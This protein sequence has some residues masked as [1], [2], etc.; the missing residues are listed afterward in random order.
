MASAPDFHRQFLST[1]TWKRRKASGANKRSALRSHGICHGFTYIRAN[2][3]SKFFPIGI[4]AERYE[5]ELNFEL[6]EICRDVWSARYA[7]NILF[8][9]LQHLGFYLHATYFI[10]V[11]CDKCAVLNCYSECFAAK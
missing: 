6:K 4:R 11:S 1:A 2:E 8:P 10:V 7:V 9:E 3:C 5:G